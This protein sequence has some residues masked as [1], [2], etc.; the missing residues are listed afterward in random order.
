MGLRILRRTANFGDLQNHNQLVGKL[1]NSDLGMTDSLLIIDNPKSFEIQDL[2]P[3]FMTTSTVSTANLPVQTTMTPV[4]VIT[5]QFLLISS[6]TGAPVVEQIK[7]TTPFVDVV[8][9]SITPT[10][11]SCSSPITS[12]ASSIVPILASQPSF[13]PSISPFKSAS[14]ST[15]QSVDHTS[16]STSITHARSTLDDNALQ[17]ADHGV[18]TGV[19]IMA[20]F[21]LILVICAVFHYTYK[22]I[23]TRIAQETNTLEG[24]RGN[25]HSTAKISKTADKNAHISSPQEFYDFSSLGDSLAD[26]SNVSDHRN[27]QGMNNRVQFNNHIHPVVSE[28]FSVNE[29]DYSIM[30]LT[31]TST[32]NATSYLDIERASITMYKYY[33]FEKENAIIQ[34]NTLNNLTEV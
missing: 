23:K 19:V 12:T 5:T 21:G 15:T 10:S 28:E 7:I 20:V 4:H 30:R 26:L 14:P 16:T 31:T 17:S 6:P 3:S 27:R 11:S 13:Y 18:K 8:A 9:A 34:F 1:Q 25:L 32:S 29:T 22:P 24:S 33:E 2:D